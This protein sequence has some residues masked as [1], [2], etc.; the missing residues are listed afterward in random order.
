[1]GEIPTRQGYPSEGNPHYRPS[2]GFPHYLYI[3]GGE[4]KL[5]GARRAASASTLH[6]GPIASDRG[7]ASRRG[8]PR[9]TIENE[10]DTQFHRLGLRRE[11]TLVSPETLETKPDFVSSSRPSPS[12]EGE[13]DGGPGRTLR[14]GHGVGPSEGAGRYRHWPLAREFTGQRLGGP[15]RRRRPEARRDEQSAQGQDRGSAQTWI[16]NGTFVVVEGSD[17]KREKRNF[18]EV[19]TAANG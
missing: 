6:A 18:M 7:I 14:W 15:R 2:G 19:G 9:A 4:A 5:P 8:Y 1:V 16:A 11:A 10:N 3:S 13:R 12:R 17:A